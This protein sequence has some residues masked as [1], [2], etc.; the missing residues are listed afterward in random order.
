MLLMHIRHGLPGLVNGDGLFSKVIAFSPGGVAAP[1]ANGMPPV[2]ISGG[3][4]DTL[5][6]IAEAELPAACELVASGFTVA[7]TTFDGGHTVPANVASQALN[8][9]L[10]KA[11]V[12]GPSP[13]A[14]SG[15]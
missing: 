9:F 7:Y 6:P 5:F 1:T 11:Q 4:T 12:A 2:F 14:C 8:W 15:R 10:G 13:Q 3:T